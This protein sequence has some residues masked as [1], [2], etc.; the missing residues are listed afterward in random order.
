MKVQPAKPKLRV[1]NPATPGIPLPAGG[2]EVEDSSYWRRRWLRGEVLV[3][4]DLH[5]D[6]VPKKAKPAAA[7]RMKPKKEA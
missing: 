1:A 6:R 5:P 7:P 3:D 4:G 2:L